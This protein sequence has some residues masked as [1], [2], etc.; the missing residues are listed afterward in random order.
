MKRKILLWTAGVLI[1]IAVGIWLQ[2]RIRT[3]RDEADLQEQLRLARAEGIPTNAAE[4]AATI[5][6]AAPSENA[7]PLYRRLKPLLKPLGDFPAAQ[8]ALL[9]R[10]SARTLVTAR[11]LVRQAKVPLGIIDEAAGLPRCWFD[12]D[13]ADGP[14]VLF[15][16]YAD[17]KS[18]AKLLALRGSVAAAEGEVT[19]AIEDAHEIFVI[20]RHAGEEGTVLSALMAETIHATG[21]RALGAWCIIHSST[22]PYREALARAVKERPPPDLRR[23]SRDELWTV[24]TVVDWSLTHTGRDKLGLKQ[25]DLPS[26]LNPFEIFLS[27]PRAR[28]TIVKAERDASAALKLPHAKMTNARS[29]AQM[30][31][32]EALMAFPVAASVYTGLGMDTDWVERREP[33]WHARQLECTALVRALPG[34]GVARSI[35]TSDLRSPY[36]GKPLTY[37]FDGKQIRITID[38]SD[39]ASPM[40]LTIPPDELKR[41]ASKP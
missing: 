12:R 21:M 3:N 41:Q 1:L 26:P 36:D 24:L 37:V 39:P 5:Q 17:M 9:L 34:G 23:E 10:P 4:F 2:Y 35:K 25:D 32:D 33:D 7:A 22:F 11:D 18:A 6:P 14:A 27:Q 28:I 31:R 8:T 38:G 29:E 13:W 19:H 40:H 16:E 20:S 15:P 30:R